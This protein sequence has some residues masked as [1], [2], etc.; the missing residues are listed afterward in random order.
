M[1]KNLVLKSKIHNN[2]PQLKSFGFI[3]W[4]NCHIGCCRADEEPLLQFAN[5]F[6]SC[7]LCLQKRGVQIDHLIH[8]HGLRGLGE[9]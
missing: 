8:I 3:V 6:L 7:S 4:K 5:N 9:I 1:S 2:W